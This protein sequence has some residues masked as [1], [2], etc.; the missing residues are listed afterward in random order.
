LKT[1]THIL[2]LILITISQFG[3]SQ[4]V[5]SIDK[6]WMKELISN[7]SKAFTKKYQ[8]NSSHTSNYDIK[9]HRL[10]F[11]IN[12]KIFYISGEITTYF[13]PTTELDEIKFDLTDVLSVDEVLYNGESINFTQADDILTC[14]FKS[15]LVEGKLD[16]IKVSYSGEPESGIDAITHRYHNAIPIISTLS[17][18][19]GA[20]DWWPCKQDLID[21]IDS[22]EVIIETP[23]EYRSVSNGLLIGEP[24]IGNK[25]ITTWRHKY[26]IP[27]YLVAIAITNYKD[28]TIYY[29][30]I[31]GDD[32]PI[33]NHI[34]PEDL[35]SAKESIEYT[36]DV[37]KVY[38]NLFEIYPYSK[39][40]YG[41]AQFP[42]GGG[43][44]HATVSFMGNFPHDLIAHELAHQWFGDKITCGSWSDIWLNEGFATY[45]TGLTYENRGKLDKWLE[46]T[47]NYVTSLP[48][49]SVYVTDTTSVSSIFNGRLSYSKGAMVLH[50]LRWKM[51][52][53]D[54]FTAI[55]NYLKDDRLKYSYAKTEDLKS[56]FETVSGLDLTK[57]FDQWIYK[58]GYPSY[59]VEW[60]QNEDN[61]LLLFINQVQSHAS[62]E[63][64][65]M[66]VEVIVNGVGGE[67]LP[68]RLDVNQNNFK[69]NLS[70]DFEISS[71]EFDPNK[72]LI[73]KDNTVALN[74]DLE[75]TEF[76]DEQ[77]IVIVKND[78]IEVTT[79]DNS[80]KSISAKLYDTSGKL[81]IS[82][83]VKGI[84]NFSLQANNLKKGVYYLVV[85]TGDR[86]ISKTLL[87]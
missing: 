12:P 36:K 82:E 4:D 45:L 8:V 68:L 81:I 35:E 48:G 63:F 71:I 51:G 55:K 22:V 43:M 31:E 87:K 75:N 3:F 58:E 37:L 65:E 10:R 6:E 26:P 84:N 83:N 9:F 54:F 13:V 39:E 28:F 20:K 77:W 79:T 69:E 46:L 17:E 64:F 52:D 25:R 27:A 34:Y 24:I 2:I 47:I 19:Y 66:P 67:K 18:P 15:S 5:G 1:I 44:E 32:L 11:N 16:S 38:E 33:L 14:T 21:K 73:S 80:V 72:W 41:H 49:G 57:F 7:E 53:D 59:A 62:V 42:W 86:I 56:H 78:F 60:K 74:P 76:D 29:K 40:R 30:N 85:D 23:K 50:M 61:S 70:V